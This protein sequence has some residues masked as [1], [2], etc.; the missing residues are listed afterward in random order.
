VLE[1]SAIQKIKMLV[2]TCG[3]VCK[4][5][6]GNN[7]MCDENICTSALIHTACLN[8]KR[9]CQEQSFIYRYYIGV[10]ISFIHGTFVATKQ[11]YWLLKASDVSSKYLSSILDGLKTASVVQSSW[12]HI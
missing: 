10:H 6:E 12:L 2:E 1:N 5:M 4:Y 3:L 8:I 7:R 9:M 11:L